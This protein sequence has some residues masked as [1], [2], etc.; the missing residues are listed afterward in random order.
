MTRSLVKPYT[1]SY[2]NTL[3]ILCLSSSLFFSSSAIACESKQHIQLLNPVKIDTEL[4]AELQAM[5]PLKVVAVN[6]P[7]LARYDEKQQT[8]SGIGIDIFCFIT[9]ELGLSF[10]IAP[11]RD[12]T[13]ADKIRRVQAG[14]ADVFIPLSYTEER[15]KHG[16]FTAAYYQNYY[17][18]IA[19]YDENISVN[20]SE[21]LANYRVGFIEGVSLQ[22]ILESIVPLGQ[23]HP[24]NQTTSDGLFQA[25]QN[26]EIDVAV[27]N[28]QIFMEK[29]YN[30]EY[31][32]LEVIHT[33]TDYRRDYSYY[34]S[35]QPE[36][37]RLVETFNLY[38]AAIDTSATITMHKRGERNF[39]ER[40]VTQRNQR[41]LLLVAI[42]FTVLLTLISTLSLLRYR[43]MSKLLAKR[44][45]LLQQKQ[46]ALQDAYKQQKALSQTDSLTGLANRRHFDTMFSYGYQ[47]YQRTRQSISLLLLDVD[48]F[49]NVN[50]HYG[51]AVGDDYL[52]AIAT[53]LENSVF[54]STDLVARYGGEEFA[55]LLTD[56]SPEDSLKVAKR[57]SHE[58]AKLSLPNASVSPPYLTLSI[59]LA[60]IINGD[61]GVKEIFSQADAQ[62][63]IAKNTGRDQ[64]RNTIIEE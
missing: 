52:R 7:P 17:A 63:Y 33:L 61:P 4:R 18:V 59:G 24:Y 42:G 12:E 40:Y 53:T 31:L 29:R 57:I 2:R 22:P 50:D 51:H 13:V 43:R 14:D 23:L 36:H 58:I 55:C 38:I 41:Y 48:Y 1:A 11:G 44:T 35:Q 47:R 15:A 10:E 3:N 64:I 46:Q 25:V 5:K 8:Y 21:D 20:S 54:R 60:T 6:A 27:F 62:L 26:G 39:F 9:Q 37:E 45:H 28:Q 56:T 49:K 16:L 34:F 30:Q 19:H 32:N